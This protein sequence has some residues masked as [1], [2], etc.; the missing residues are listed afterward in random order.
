MFS[1][2]NFSSI[3]PGGP[4][5]P[6]APMCGRLWLRHH[7]ITQFFT[8][9]MPFLPPNQQRQSTE[10]AHHRQETT[11]PTVP[12]A[13]LFVTVS[14]TKGA[15][16]SA[17]GLTEGALTSPSEAAVVHCCC[18]DVPSTT[19]AM[20]PLACRDAVMKNTS[21]QRERLGCTHTHTHTPV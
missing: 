20:F 16:S 5:T 4:L 3:F 6:Y 10:G 9:R 15:F 2:F 1:L 7:P 17:S 8:G 11:P 13:R 14:A 12:Y 19:Y 18:R 21:C